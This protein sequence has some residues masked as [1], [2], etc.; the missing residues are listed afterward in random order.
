MSVNESKNNL[1]Q[2]KKS[3]NKNNTVRILEK[4]EAE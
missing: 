1:E 4:Q 2:K 3:N